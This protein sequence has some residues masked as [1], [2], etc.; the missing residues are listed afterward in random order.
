[1]STL[2]INGP[3]ASYTGSDSFTIKCTDSV[4]GAFSS[5]TVALTVTS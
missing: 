5:E 4:T 2:N 1:M 3:N